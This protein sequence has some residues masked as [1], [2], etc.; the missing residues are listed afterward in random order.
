ML[1]L[2]KVKYH[3][4]IKKQL[5]KRFIAFDVETTALNPKEERIIELGAVLFENG[6]AVQK[7]NTLVNA[8]VEVSE[9]ISNLTHITNEML[10]NQP[11]EEKAYEMFQEFMK[12]A[13]EGKV[14][15]CAHNAKFDMSFLKET[16]DR[17]K[18]DGKICY[19][20]TLQLSR[21]YIHGPYNYKQGTIARY[22]HIKNENAHRAYD[23]AYVCGQILNHIVKGS[24]Q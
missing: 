21:K 2:I 7:F 18:L 1:E 19:V 10:E 5:E 23:D 17:L 16:F 22:L 4:D 14:I 8:E 24:F 6:Q 9:F 3:Q 15:V 20:D 13:L 12:E 11:R